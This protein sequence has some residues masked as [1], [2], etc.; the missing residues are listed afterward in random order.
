MKNNYVVILVIV[1]VVAGLSF[2]GGIQYQLRQTPS[3][4]NLAQFA[5]G[6][7]AIGQNGTKTNGSNRFAQGSRPLSGEITG[8]DGQSL[9]LKLADGSS[10]TVIISD[11]TAINRTSEATKE[12]LATGTTVTVF[13]AADASGTITAQNIGIG[14]NLSAFGNQPVPDAPAQP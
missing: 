11:Q 4:G 14:N 12:D 7:P 10:K 5:N 2:Y 1:A 8:R 9:T 3:R 13:G 6:S